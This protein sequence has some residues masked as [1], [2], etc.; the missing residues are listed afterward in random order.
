MTDELLHPL[1][2][3]FAMQPDREDVVLLLHGWTGSPAHLR[4]LGADLAE[5]GFGV[6]APLLPGHGTH[7]SDL[8]ATGWKDWVETA[9]EA[10]QRIEEAGSRLHLGGLSM[11]GLVAILLSLPFPAV[12]VTTINSPIHLFSRT[13]RLAPL[14]RGT[15]RIRIEE[16]SPR[17]P[18][19]AGDYA[20]HYEGTPI[21]SVADVLTLI[22][23]AKKALPRVSAPSLVIQSRA[24]ETVRPSSAWYIYERLGAP[25]KRLVWLDDSA[26]V[27]TLDVERHRV[28]AEMARHLRDAQGLASLHPGSPAG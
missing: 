3:G 20:H 21:G 24:D 26:H 22:R 14:M 10:A 27:A 4:L 8:F 1:A 16:R 9:A 25:F 11:G 5:A 6:V 13:A 17:N 28:S 18:G 15:D 12:S 23:A 19:F 2:A 7:V